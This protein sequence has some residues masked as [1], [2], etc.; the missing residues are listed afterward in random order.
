MT[1][2]TIASAHQQTQTTPTSG[3]GCPVL[4]ATS[5]QSSSWDTKATVFQGST[6]ECGF[7]ARSQRA[8]SKY[9]DMA[10]VNSDQ[11]ISA[12]TLWASGTWRFFG[13][14]AL[15][16]NCATSTCTTSTTGWGS[17]LSRLRFRTRIL[18]VTILP[19]GQ[20]AFAVLRSTSKTLKHP[21]HSK[22]VLSSGAQIKTAIG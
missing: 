18:I 8:T 13:Q 12:Q 22:P 19:S 10:S 16:S 14:R 6:L 2:R 4:L 11:T 5:R 21:Y 9:A 1:L 20:M 17:P 7:Q 3:Y 15:I